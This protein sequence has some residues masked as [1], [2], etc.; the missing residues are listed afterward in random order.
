MFY[1]TTPFPL[2]FL[3]GPPFK[4]VFFSVTPPN[5]TSPPYL[6]KNERSPISCHKGGEV[7]GSEGVC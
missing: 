2:F 5:F 3:D 1:V 7:K 4:A 6:V